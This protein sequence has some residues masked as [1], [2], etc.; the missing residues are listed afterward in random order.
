ML[1]AVVLFGLVT[2]GFVVPCLIDV[3]VTPPYELRRLTKPA[4]VVL[5]VFF[6]A[7][8]AAA[9]LAVGRPDQRRRMIPRHLEDAPFFGPLDALRRHPAS[10]GM[11]TGIG[12]P[13][14]MAAYPASSALTR[15]MGPDDDPEFLEE[16][17]RRIKRGRGAGNDA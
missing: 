9:W 14:G 3:A 11:D 4:W 8:G 6:S 7:F 2:V 15:P 10:R 12:G 16:L 17:A 13:S 1:L 5:I